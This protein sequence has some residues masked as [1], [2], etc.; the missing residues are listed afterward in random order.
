MG[1]SVA[2]LYK[3]QVPKR[4]RRQV[5]DMRVAFRNQVVPRR[6]LPDFLVIGAQRS[7]TSS[8]YKW[9]GQH[10]FVLPSLRKETE[11]FS[12]NFGR[13]EAWYRAHFPSLLRRRIFREL[14]GHDALSFEATPYYLFHPLAPARVARLVPDA[15]LIVLLRNPV[16]RA[17]S[18]YHH[19]VRHGS[20]TRSFE[21]A[22]KSE[23]E[24]VAADIERLQVDPLHRSL[25]HHRFSYLGR[26]RYAEQLERWL[27][28]FGRDRFLVLS[29]EELYADP[30][31]TYQQVLAFLGLPNAGSS[32]FRNHSYTSG[33]SAKHGPMPEEVRRWLM[34]E[35]EPENRR[36]FRLLQC[37]FGW[38]S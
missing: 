35:F 12:L 4:Y 14:R 16:D 21:E 10:P 8:L 19:M 30:S 15:K 5:L 20:E 37:D 7:G 38:N 17:Y 23:P 13:G 18:H 33:A 31:S 27:A 29:S 34:E 11:Y 1:A 25:A 2:D 3:A 9:L 6:S 24:R 22:I 26:G 36:L 28:E 32:G